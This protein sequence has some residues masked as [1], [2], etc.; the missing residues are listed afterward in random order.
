[1][2]AGPAA[3]DEHPEGA[4]VSGVHGG[5]PSGGAIV[6]FLGGADVLGDLAH[7]TRTPV[8][9]PIDR[10]YGRRRAKAC[11]ERTRISDPPRAPYTEKTPAEPST[12]A[13]RRTVLV[14]GA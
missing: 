10:R 3:G 2:T 9:D 11:R 14:D 4:A 13:F 5:C 7:A 8:E 12:G 6:S 1:M